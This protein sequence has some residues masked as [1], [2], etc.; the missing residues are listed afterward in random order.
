MYWNESE[1]ANQDIFADFKLK[2]TLWFLSI[3]QK[4]LKEWY[5][6]PDALLKK[7]QSQ[8]SFSVISK[9]ITIYFLQNNKLIE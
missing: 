1:R 5:I 4:Y 8:G 7:I 3:I 6:K 9:D 2:K